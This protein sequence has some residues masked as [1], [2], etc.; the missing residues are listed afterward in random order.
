[1]FKNKFKK[2]TG[3]FLAAV[4]TLVALPIQTLASDWGVGDN[5]YAAMLGNYIG[6]DGKTYAD[7]YNY[8]YIYYKSDGSVGVATR[9]AST[10]AKL[11]VSK[12]GVTQQAI[13]IEAGVSYSTGSSY[14]GKASSDDYML[15]LPTKAQRDLKIEL[16]SGFNSQ[17]TKSPVAN[18]N[19]DDFSFA[20]QIISWEIQ[21]GL[22]TGY[23]K[24]DLAVNSSIPNT[25]KTAYYDQLKGR[26]AE[27]C[28]EYILNKMK[29]Y[30]IVPSFT[31]RAKATAPTHTMKYDSS[32]KKYSITLTDENNSNM[33]AS[34]FNISGVTVTKSSNKYTFSTTTKISG[35]KACTYKANRTSGDQLVIWK[36]GNGSQTMASGID[37]PVEF[38]ANFKTSDLGTVQIKKV[39]QH[40]GDQTASNKDI[41]FTIKNSAGATVKGTGSAGSYTYS[42]SGSVSQ[43]RLNSSNTFLV[44][45]LPTGT[46][47]VTEHGSTDY[48]IS[49]GAS[50]TVTV[51]VGGTS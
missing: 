15:M 36:S 6:S 37:D 12:N 2:L 17:V 27:K 20:T 8:D 13:C 26:P 33:P 16:I 43:F 39:W 24:S 34:A 46:Y 45:S 19:L 48:T 32:I 40:N 29:A 31:G 23:G 14:V 50:K 25:P 10:H 11:G 49:G 47:T 44:K 42:A 51:P 3:L 21:Q 4:M 7:K 35:T 18:T 9:Y 5:V 30:S 22:R 41:Y 1:M 28:Y 38:Y